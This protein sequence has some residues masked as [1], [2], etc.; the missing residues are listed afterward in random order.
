MIYSLSEIDA[1]CKKAARGAGFSWGYAEEIGKAARW[2]AAYQLPGVALL[3]QYLPLRQE[4]PE[5]Y[6][7]IAQRCPILTG[8]GLCDGG[9]DEMQTSVSVEQVVYPLLLLP[10]LA[11]LSEAAG[12]A[13][14]VQWTGT[15]LTY[16]DGTI[17]IKEDAGIT[18]NAATD[19]SC[20]WLDAEDAAETGDAQEKM[21]VGQWVDDEHWAALESLAHRTYVP[22][23]EA[24][25][26][27]AG[28]AD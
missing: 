12:A 28:P 27:G 1:N 22:A 5:D 7:G 13:L 26:R 15:H 4:K 10:S 19:V 25:R 24:S 14:S 6:L 21:T 16:Q 17:F 20:H 9:R 18:S 23:T 2:L 11:Q 8:S 3:A